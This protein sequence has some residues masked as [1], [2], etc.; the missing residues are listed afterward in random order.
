MKKLLLTSV[1][2]L[3]LL[4]TGALAQDSSGSGQSGASQAPAGQTTAPASGQTGG[5][6]A[7]DQSSGQKSD[8]KPAPTPDQVITAQ[9][10]SELLGSWITGTTVK[11]TSGED[12]G[13]IQ[14]ILVDKSNAKVTGVVLAVGGFLGVGAKAIAVDWKDLKIDYDANKITLDL[15]RKQADAAPAYKFRDQKQPPAPAPSGGTGGTGTTGGTM[16]TGGAGAAGSGGTSGG[17]MTG[18]GNSNGM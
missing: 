17:G 4:S 2:V 6:Q 13:K 16:G 10:S 9:D 5:G 1:C 7:A 11:S 14:D 18:G 8:Q 15:T 3:S 12:I